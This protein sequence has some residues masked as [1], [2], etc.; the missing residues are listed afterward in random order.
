MGSVALQGEWVQ[1]PRM[2][3]NK[4]QGAHETKPLFVM[5]FILEQFQ[6]LFFH[7]QGGTFF[8]KTKDFPLKSVPI[9]TQVENPTPNLL[10]LLQPWFN[11]HRWTW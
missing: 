3:P 9:Q 6:L 2:C 1:P 10:F 5:L 8:Q 11:Q 7:V 4:Q